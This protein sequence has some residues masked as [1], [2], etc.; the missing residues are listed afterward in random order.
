MGYTHYWRRGK[1][2][3]KTK[4]KAIVG[5]FKKVLPELNKVIDLAGGDGKG[6]PTI[7][8]DLVSFNGRKDCNHPI[9]ELWITWP[10]KNASGVAKPDEDAKEGYWFGG[11][12]LSKRTCGGD[13]SHETCFFPRVM[14]IQGWQEQKEG[15]YSE[16]CKTAFKPYDLAVISFLIIAKHHLN[17][18]LV[19]SSD[20]TDEHWLD[21]KQLC[22]AVLGYGLDFQLRVL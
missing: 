1:T 8:Y 22:Q 17:G 16:F 7:D 10:G 20:G 13:C 5:D 11:A 15:L 2:I 3:P 4:M 19:V 14:E 9:K 21:G 18:K 6:K 12:Q